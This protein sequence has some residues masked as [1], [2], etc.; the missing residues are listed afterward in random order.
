MY[1]III[2]MRKKL[3]SLV[4]TVSFLLMTGCVYY[5][6][7][8]NAKQKFKEAEQNQLNAQK[9][10][11]NKTD[12]T[13]HNR[14]D[15][16]IEPSISANDKTLYKAAIDKANKVVMY[17]PESKFID[18]ALWL[19]GKSRY[20][21]A[22]FVSADKKLR[23][24]I[25]RD[26]ESE[27]VDDAYYYIGMSQF[28]LK[29]YERAQEAFNN[30]LE[31]KKSSYKDDAAFVIAY[32]EYL[33]KNFSSAVTFFEDFQS[34]YR[35]SDSASTA[36]FFVAVCYDSL[37]ENQSALSAY[38]KI[39]KLNPSIDLYFDAQFAYGSS[40]FMADSIELGMSVFS[41]LAKNQRYFDKLSI[42]RVKYAE[43]LTLMG[44]TDEAIKVFLDVCEKY[45]R[46]DQSS[47]AYYRLGVIYQD[48]LFNLEK[49]KEYFNKATQEKKDSGYRNISLSRAAQISKLET[50]RLKLGLD[51]SADSAAQS[52]A[53]VDD[54]LSSPDTSN[55]ISPELKPRVNP[56]LESLNI[57]DISPAFDQ[58]A[59]GMKNES[60]DS[61]VSDATPAADTIVHYQ[62][63]LNSPPYDLMAIYYEDTIA[64][65]VLAEDGKE[66]TIDSTQI[67]EDIEV[68]FLL[69]ELYH[70]DL[71]RPD[72]ALGEYMLLVSNFPNSEFAPRS[73]LASAFIYE[74]KGDTANANGLYRRLVEDYPISKQAQYAVNQLGDVKIPSE[75][76]VPAMYTEAEKLY[77]ENNAPDSALSIFKY[78]SDNFPNSEYAVKSAY[79]IAYIQ[80]QL[81]VERTDSSVYYLYADIVEQYPES[82]YAYGAKLAMG[83]E[84][85]V[86]PNVKKPPHSVK[87]RP[88][89]KGEEGPEQGEFDDS[90]F[91]GMLYAPPALDSIAFLYPE[92][93]LDEGHREKGKV[94]FKIKIDLFG[95]ITE[96]QLLG[97]SGN[98]LIDSAATEAL[99]STTFDTSGLDDLSLLDGYFRYDI[100]FDPPDNWEDRYERS[101]EFERYNQDFERGP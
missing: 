79:A 12:G 100:R 19:I 1:I 57:A 29:D 96:H 60:P 40:A 23:E 18:D 5:N 92:S 99:L 15:D 46:T 87:K 80:D 72:S 51:V 64:D 41:S 9:S 38:R 81:D 54:T 94:I 66:K 34:E 35:K 30:V 78:I 101:S 53:V 24:L 85:R 89:E 50:Y 2:N 28:W 27:Y 75:Y 61:N 65:S 17:H 62:E 14:A 86:D 68:R 37:G 56:G 88:T 44:N 36:Q 67:Y 48:I 43:G 73:L 69:A 52:Q 71:N 49:A 77:Y 16:P 20:N 21:M 70:H 3:L 74:S 13:I 58:I 10:S 22:E 7:F 83:L 98:E 26:P 63:L 8:Y 90:L 84:A 59:D 76:N 91:A 47:E 6:L 31:L 32:I 97:T 93:L 11:S 4:L 25:I 55:T 45:P 39:E 95:N 33:K 42:I 82:K